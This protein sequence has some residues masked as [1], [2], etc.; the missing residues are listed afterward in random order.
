MAVSRHCVREAKASAV[1]GAMSANWVED[2][3]W[4]GGGKECLLIGLVGLL[5]RPR[6]TASESLAIP[7]IQS[8]D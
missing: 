5:A 3:F 2:C 6:R 7:W 1:L 4:G 8:N